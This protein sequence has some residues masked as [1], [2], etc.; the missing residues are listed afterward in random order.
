M[1]FGVEAHMDCVGQE[2]RLFVLAKSRRSYPVIQ[3]QDAD[4]RLSGVIDM[5]RVFLTGGTAAALVLCIHSLA[6]ALGG[7]YPEGPLAEQHT[8]WPPGLFELAKSEGRVNGYWV[9]SND[10]FFYRGDAES[11]EKFLAVYGKVGDTPLMV[12]LH[13]G[14]V[15]LTG[16]LGKP[17]T[18]PFDW[19]LSV[20]RR[21]WGAPLDPRRPKDDPGYVATI[22]IWLSDKLPLDRL[23]IPKHI[24]VSSAG[25]IQKFIER[26]KSRE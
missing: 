15:P 23:K 2:G 7:N 22:H 17:K 1:H 13:A 11:L 4:G 24:D 8:D 14:A 20:T 10:F 12:V 9:N 26:H 5:R 16:S 21:G 19:Q 18:I 25:D 3:R 6:F